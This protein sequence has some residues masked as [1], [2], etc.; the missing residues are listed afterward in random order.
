MENFT[1]IIKSLDSIITDVTVYLSGAEI[2]RKAEIEIE[3]GVHKLIFQNLPG[4]IQPESVQVSAND[5]ATILSVNHRLD[6]FQVQGNTDEIEKLQEELQALEK[7]ERYENSQLELCGLEFEMFSNNMKLGGDHTGLKA[8]ELK[9]AIE[10]YNERMASIK[11]RELEY[12]YNI[13]EIQ[14]KIQQI[15]NQLNVHYYPSQSAPTSE[16]TVELSTQESLLVTLALTYSVQSASW[17]P[18]YD[19]RS[20]DIAGT[21]ELNYKA[22]VCQSSGE[23]WQNVKLVLSAGNPSENGQCPD[24][25]PWYIDFYNEASHSRN[26]SAFNAIPRMLEKK[27]MVQDCMVDESIALETEDIKEA[28]YVPPV[29]TSET[30]TSMEYTIR[31]TYSILSGKEKCVE[32]MVYSLPAKYRYFS[33]RKLE[34]EVFLLASIKDWEH[35]NLL[36]GNAC[37]YFENKFVG[38]TYID[39]RKASEEIDLSLGTDKRVIVTRVKGKSMSE[40]TL[41]GAL[42]QTRCWNLTV[43]NLKATD[44]NIRLIDQIPVSTNKQIQI[45]AV[46]IS[47]AEFNKDNG[48]LTWDLS[49]KPSESKSFD[50]KYTVTHPK[51]TKVLL[52]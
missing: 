19:I 35:L 2:T 44:I 45:D 24:M 32:I 8:A 9:S 29:Q 46:E 14:Q 16:V 30:P 40:K 3:A 11:E 41:T 36:A 28:I 13:E 10:F 48:L 43:R 22:N 20:K 4:C 17:H 5:G 7:R 6:Y 18:I 27:M 33:A 47:G 51:N 25:Q 15:R 37:V 21:V 23:D 31:D 42:K 50:V 34:K 26:V 52:D 1:Q 39:P 12:T 49:L 38:K